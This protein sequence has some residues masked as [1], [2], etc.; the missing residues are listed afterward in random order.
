MDYTLAQQLKDAGFPFRRIQRGDTHGHY[1]REVFTTT[2]DNSYLIPILEELIEA[3]G[4]EF[5]T[6]QKQGVGK[7]MGW[8]AFTYSHIES[9]F[10]ES[11][12]IA[13]AYL[14]LALNKK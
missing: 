3:C 6:L 7:G 10:G 2:D 5:G 13:V 1:W 14:Y 8:F 11:P 4:S 12:D 9:Y